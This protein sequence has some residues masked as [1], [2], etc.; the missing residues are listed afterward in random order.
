MINRRP[1]L[2]EI[3][4]NFEPIYS[5]TPEQYDR[6]VNTLFN[7]VVGIISRLED[8]SSPVES[9][10]IAQQARD[11]YADYDDD[12]ADILTQ[13]LIASSRTD[14]APY[15]TPNGGAIFPD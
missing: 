9:R 1:S 7:F 3:D 11:I 5:L 6:L 10:R 14:D 4:L 8:S 2:A 13:Y 15:P 12:L